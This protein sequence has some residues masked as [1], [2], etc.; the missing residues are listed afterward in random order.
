MADPEVDPRLQLTPSDC[1][2][3][4]RY[5]RRISDD[6]HP[7]VAPLWRARAKRFEAAARAAL[8]EE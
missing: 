1:V 3:A 5:F 7:E 6:I 2:C 8:E 4:A